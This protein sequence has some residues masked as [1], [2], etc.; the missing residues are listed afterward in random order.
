MRKETFG[1]ALYDLGCYNTSLILRLLGEEPESVQAVAVY[2]DRNVDRLTTGTLTFKG[3]MSAAFTCG[4]VLATDMD[5]RLDRLQIH[6]TKGKIVSDVEYNQEGECSFTVI[7]E[8]GTV[9]RTVT[10]RQNYA[11][12]TE[13]FGRCIRQG[14]TPFVSNEFTMMNSRTIDRLLESIGY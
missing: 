6:G 1:G 9:V 14:E 2:S 11:L 3:G 7:T 5:Q 8:E 12:E 13:Q 4:M 10:A